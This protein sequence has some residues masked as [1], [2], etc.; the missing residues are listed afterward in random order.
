MTRGCELLHLNCEAFNRSLPLAPN[1]LMQV[2]HVSGRPDKGSSGPPKPPMPSIDVEKWRALIPVTRQ[3]SYFDHAAVGPT[4]APTIDAIRQTLR[5]QSERGSLEHPALFQLA[6]AVRDIF[7][8]FCGAKPRNIALAANTS[9]AISTVARGI[10]WRPGD[11][12]VVPEIDFPCVVL[13]WKMLA[14]RGVELRIV[15]CRHGVISIADLL[16]ACTSRTRVLAVSW[17]QFTSGYRVDLYRLGTECRAR[18]ILLVVDIMQGLGVL[19][20]DLESLPVDAAAADSYKWMLGPQGVGWLYLND[21]LAGTLNISSVGWRT[22]TPRSS[23]CDHSFDLRQGAAR[24][25]SGALNLHGIAGVKESLAMLTGIGQEAIAAR[26]L[27]L[28]QRL[29]AGLLKEGCEIL[30][31][32]ESPDRQAAIVAFRHPRKNPD[33]LYSALLRDNI[34]TSVRE[35]CV[36]VSPHFYNTEGEIDRLLTFIR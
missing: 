33:E 7:A 24:H 22:L 21:A 2:P 14:S 12:V 11:Q 15:P 28:A 32:Q 27:S 18:G 19:P 10:D 8:A 5:L 34:V 23:F 17:V 9:S 26:A 16:A 35:G 36:R 25:E 6:E 3:Y 13:P 20:I 30:G 4:P 31:D 29:R 1:L